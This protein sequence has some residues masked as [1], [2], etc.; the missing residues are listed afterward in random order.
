MQQAQYFVCEDAEILQ[1]LIVRRGDTSIESSIGIKTKGMSA[2]EGLDFHTPPVDLIQFHSGAKLLLFL[3][4]SI[5]QPDIGLGGIS[6]ENVEMLI[7]FFVDVVS[8]WF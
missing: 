4:V 2:K 1:V 8:E 7:A 5:R 6:L 3:T